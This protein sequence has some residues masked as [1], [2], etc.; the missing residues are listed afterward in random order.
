MYSTDEA[1]KELV[2]P[3]L[4]Q[5]PRIL[6]TVYHTWEITNWNELQKREHGP[7]FEAGGYPW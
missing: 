1:I 7:I 2:L 5:Q 4:D 3:P 6:E